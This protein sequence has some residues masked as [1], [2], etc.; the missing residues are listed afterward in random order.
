[1]HEGEE[2]KW[3]C[4]GSKDGKYFINS[5][6]KSFGRK[7]KIMFYSDIDLDDFGVSYCFVFIFIGS[8]MGK[9]L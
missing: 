8:D 7:I 5:F 6:Y 3:V 1:M 2:Y 4:V 9:K